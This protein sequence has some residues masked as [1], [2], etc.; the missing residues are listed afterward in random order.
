MSLEEEKD[1]KIQDSA[2]EKVINGV[3]M[4]MLAEK[5]PNYN[6]AESEK[7]IS[8]LNNT[9]IV[10]GRD[11]PADIFSGYGGKGQ[12]KCGSIDIVAG[13]TSAVIRDYDGD[14][15][16]YTDPSIVFDASRI[17]ISQKSD[18]DDN[19]YL[20]GKS[21]KG[22]ASIAIKSDNIRIIAREAIKLVANNDEFDSNGEL[23]VM[24]NGIHLYGSQDS[25]L[26]PMVMGDNLSEFLDRIL[27]QI[28]QNTSEITNIYKILLS[29]SR[30]LARHTHPT[31][32]GIASPSIELGVESGKISAEI[33]THTISTQTQQA[34]I[35]INKINY[36]T[37]MSKRSIMSKYHK[38]D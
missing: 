6:E 21:Y 15:K 2:K 9:Y 33:S 36:L 30:S 19:F 7:V 31:P 16:V 13:R 28:G 23:K 27:E 10:L 25:K 32:T 18:V 37:P 22:K 35:K 17:T 1:L 38:L 5:L 14:E 8:G 26:Q 3:G 12:D 29:L 4:T 11:R 24:N 20:P 34:N